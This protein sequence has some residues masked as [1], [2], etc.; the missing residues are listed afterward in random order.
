MKKLLLVIL[1]T[2]SFAFA[3]YE[4]GM[5]YLKLDKPVATTVAGDK[6]EVRELFWYG[7][8]HCYH[9]EPTL[10]NWLKNKPEAAE[11][12]RQPAIFSKQWAF[13]AMHYYT[14]ENLGLI[15]KLHE[16]LFALIHEKNKRFRSNEDFINWVAGFGVDKEK[17]EKTLKSFSTKTKV[18]KAAVNTNKYKITGVPVIIVAGKYV[19][20]ASHAGNRNEMFKVV[21]FLVQ[22]ESENK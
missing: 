4:E 18:R 22:K 12:I 5:E 8:P 13:D 9:L 17:V 11:F 19:T 21:D 10:N 6:V 2:S 16:P 3:D 14:L 15:E 20:D 1:F 7:C